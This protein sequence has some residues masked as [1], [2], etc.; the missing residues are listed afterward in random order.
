MKVLE[1]F[2]DRKDPQAIDVQADEDE[3][4]EYDVEEIVDSVW[5]KGKVLYRI[6]WQ[7]YTPEDDTWEKLEDMSCAVKL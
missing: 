7:R 4:I 3:N 1:P 6:R 2:C 5:R